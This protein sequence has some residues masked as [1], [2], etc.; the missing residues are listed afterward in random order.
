MRSRKSCPI[1]NPWSGGDG[2]RATRVVGFNA[3]Q[4]DAN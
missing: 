1:R 3:S 4:D 2:F